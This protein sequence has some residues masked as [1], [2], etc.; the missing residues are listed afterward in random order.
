M[1]GSTSHG[2][3][4]GDIFHVKSTPAS[5]IPKNIA[6][7]NKHLVPHQD[8]SYY[9]SMPGLQLLHFRQF[10]CDIVGG[11][12]TLVDALAAAEEFRRL[13]P[14]HFRTLVSCQATF[15][16]Q[17]HGACMTYSRPHIVLAPSLPQIPPCVS[18]DNKET[19]V[20]VRNAEI[21]AVNWSPPFEGPLSIPPDMVLPYYE[22]YSAF[23]Q[24]LDV[25]A[26][27]QSE[28]IS[29]KTYATNNSENEKNIT[30]MSQ[31]ES[32]E[33]AKYAQHFTWIYKLQ[34]GEMLVF[35]NRRLLHGRMGF[36]SSG[37]D[38]NNLTT[39]A[40][41]QKD[42]RSLARHL[43][44]A[45]TNMDDTVNRYRALLRSRKQDTKDFAFT[46]NVGNGTSILP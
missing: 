25:T 35:N 29:M 46:R 9:E 2:T 37:K 4:Y 15:V 44:G 38:S 40:V 41:Q 1:A 39:S 34:P 6:F 14:H 18:S 12:S 8:L 28:S 21:V 20:F 22:A 45:Y 26:S 27:V 31:E 43:V 5:A 17:R 23:E 32:S 33:F 19:E 7:T 10:G 24:M 13:A 3:L 30:A 11:E 16:K 42:D 36:T